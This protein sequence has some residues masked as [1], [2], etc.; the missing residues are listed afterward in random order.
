MS[1]LDT[2][3]LRDG[4]THARCAR[5]DPERNEQRYCYLAWQVGA[6]G[7]WRLVGIRGRL[8]NQEQHL[9]L[10]PFPDLAAAV[11]RLSP[12]GLVAQTLH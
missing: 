5:V 2:A 8:G 10:R 7:D 6:L 9:P 4:F 12:G 3:A 11:P 1:S